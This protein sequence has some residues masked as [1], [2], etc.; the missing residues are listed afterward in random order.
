MALFKQITISDWSGGISDSKYRG[1]P[2]SHYEMVGVDIHSEPGIAKVQNRMDASAS[3]LKSKIRWFR[4]STSTEVWALGGTSAD[5]PQL[6]KSTDS[7]T[8]W[9]KKYPSQDFSPGNG[10]GFALWRGYLFI[11]GDS[12]IDVWNGNNDSDWVGWKSIDTDVDYH[13]MWMGE[14]DGS[15]YIGCGRYVALLSE[16]SGQVF[17][18]ANSATYSWNSQ[19]LDI[20]PDFKIRSMEEIGNYLL[21]GCWR[22][23]SDGKHS[24]VAIIYPWNYILRPSS[25]EGPISF[26]RF[27]G[28]SAMLNINNTVYSW[29]GP[30]G[31][32]FYYNGS[33][34]VKLKKIPD[35]ATD[36]VEPGAVVSNFNDIPLFGLENPTSGGGGIY[37]YGFNNEKYPLALTLEY[38]LSPGQAASYTIGA[39]GVNGTTDAILLAGWQSGNSYGIDYLNTSRRYGSAYITTRLM[40]IGTAQKKQIID[41]FQ[42][43]LDEVLATSGAIN[44]KYRK[45]TND[46]WTTIKTGINTKTMAHSE[47]GAKSEIYVPFRINDVVNLQLKIEFEVA[48]D[49]NTTPKLREITL[50]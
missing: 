30:R 15:L 2:G 13:P 21:L 32:I 42:I 37:S 46:S 44:L 41:G 1:I 36:V 16:T 25:H 39:V 7:G 27:K 23:S 18:P 31:E 26:R 28:V 34:L 50:Q 47:V 17:S 20:P 29:V 19:A 43:Y 40:R 14:R 8:T 33:K 49:N 35:Y 24:P 45:H 11:A 9:T 10:N 38:P 5:S 4:A 12:K 22:V 6:Y 3:T 48:T